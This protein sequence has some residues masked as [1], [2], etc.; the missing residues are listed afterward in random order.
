M[1]PFYPIIFHLK[2]QQ[3]FHILKEMSKKRSS[4]QQTNTKSKKQRTA[5]LSFGSFH[6]SYEI[7]YLY[8]EFMKKHKIHVSNTTKGYEYILIAKPDFGFTALPKNATMVD[9]NFLED[10]NNQDKVL[11]L[12]N[13]II[14]NENFLKGIKFMIAL[15]EQRTKE[16]TEW[17]IR[18]KG[19]VFKLGECD[20]AV[21]GVYMITSDEYVKQ[22]PKYF[23]FMRKEHYSNFL[24]NELFIK[25]LQERKM[26]I[27]NDPKYDISKSVIDSIDWL[28]YTVFEQY[29]KRKQKRFLDEKALNYREQ[30]LPKANVFGK[31]PNHVSFHILK[32]LPPKDLMNLRLVCK[33]AEPLCLQSSLWKEICEYT[34]KGNPWI[35]QIPLETMNET[36]KHWYS[37]YR[38]HFV[39]ILIDRKQL[40]TEAKKIQFEDP[41]SIDDLGRLGMVMSLRP[42]KKGSIPLGSTKLGGTPDLPD[43]IKW[44]KECS[45]IMQLNL[46]EIRP[47]MGFSFFQFKFPKTGILYFFAD[48]EKSGEDMRVVFYY[49][50][51][52][53]K[54][55]RTDYSEHLQKWM[56]YKECEIKFFERITVNKTA[57]EFVDVLPD[58]IEEPSLHFFGFGDWIFD[59]EEEVDPESR[60][61]CQ[62]SFNEES[63]M[64]F[65]LYIILM[66]L[67]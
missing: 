34:L 10:C 47:Q 4:S 55:K 33:N 35:P 36:K 46:Q 37:F 63:N 38:E 65:G 23:H 24:K 45:F 58:L 60:L 31:V 42:V 54:L 8:Q 28:Q 53:S 51:D 11:P 41:I 15:D 27:S 26:E 32:Y 66:R 16:Y 43:S 9:I 7:T 67:I 64:Q 21:N 56:R 50:G 6:S 3:K 12:D 62:I 52:L 61:L 29:E 59:N 57:F 30:Q 18:H 22:Y 44:P 5:N 40:E 13:Y 19:E 20:I 17:I 39:P 49:N 25:D 2:Y 48:E 14:T 1:V